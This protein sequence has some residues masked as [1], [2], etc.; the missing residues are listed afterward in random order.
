MPWTGTSFA[1]KHNHR[2]KGRAAK[3]AAKVATGLV[4]KGMDEGKAIRIANAQGDKLQASADHRYR[5]RG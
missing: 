3:E 5:N 4:N 1:E 2:L